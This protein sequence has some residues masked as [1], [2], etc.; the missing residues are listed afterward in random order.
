MKKKRTIITAPKGWNAVNIKELL[1]SK[2]LLVALVMRDFKM[3][4]RQTLVGVFW[5][6]LQPL[7]YVMVFT[8]IMNKVGKIET[9]EIPYSVF[10]FIGI[11]L[12]QLYSRALNEGS[13]CFITE[14]GI[15]SKIYF[16]RLLMPLTSCIGGLFDFSI[17]LIVLLAYI[18]ILGFVPSITILT[19][20]VFVLMA[21]MAALGMSLWLSTLNALYRDVRYIVSFFTQFML[22][23]TPVFYSLDSVPSNYLWLYA[24]NPLVM[25]IEGM[26]WALVGGDIMAHFPVVLTSG[27]LSIVLLI[28]GTHFFRQMENRVVDFL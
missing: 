25:P 4:F 12:F 6:I 26:R 15:V 13:N 11:T 3:R 18:L 27:I 2:N 16:P 1:D 17:V 20:P 23:V 14:R 5:V 7:M 9:G 10:S 19:L 24:I 8:L 22:F 28:S 21:L